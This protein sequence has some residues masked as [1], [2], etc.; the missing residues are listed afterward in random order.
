VHVDEGIGVEH[1]RRRINPV[2][3]PAGFGEV[4]GLHGAI[5]PGLEIAVTLPESSPL[6]PSTSELNS[7]ALLMDS[8]LIGR[9]RPCSARI[10]ASCCWLV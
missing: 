9:L 8:T 1:A 2:V 7:H 4:V 6:Q 3:Q 10:W 5:E